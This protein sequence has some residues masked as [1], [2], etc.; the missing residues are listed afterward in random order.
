MLKLSQLG[1]G[2]LAVVVAGAIAA[3]AVTLSGCGD[4]KPKQRP[5]PDG[6]GDAAMICSGSFTSPVD[7]AMLTVADDLNKSC[8]GALHTNISLATSADD[9]TNVDLYVNGAK[10]DT[11][12]ASGAEVHFLNVQLP[13]G[14]DMLQA[15]VSATCTLKATVTVNCNLPTCTITALPARPHELERR[16]LYVA[17]ARG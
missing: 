4:N 9:G 16:V 1:H 2:T 11:Q 14:T 3:G 6:G 17:L 5:T 15:V 13:Q 7:G 12:K 8:T 10:V